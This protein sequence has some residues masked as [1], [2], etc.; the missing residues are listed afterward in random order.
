MYFCDEKGFKGM[1]LR[2]KMEVLT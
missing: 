1:M 2:G